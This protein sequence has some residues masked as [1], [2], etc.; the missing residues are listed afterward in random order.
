MH[1]PTSGAKDSSETVYP[2]KLKQM[3]KWIDST[4]HWKGD[5]KTEDKSLQSDFLRN[6]KTTFSLHG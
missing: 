3:L 1:A 4:V 6:Q 2:L 5:A